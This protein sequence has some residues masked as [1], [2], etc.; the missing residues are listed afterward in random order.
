[1]SANCTKATNRHARSNVRFWGQLRT[2]YAKIE[3]F[4]S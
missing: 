1:M 3:F 2:R 4:A